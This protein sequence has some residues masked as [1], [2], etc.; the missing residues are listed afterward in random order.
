MATV[1]DEAGQVSTAVRAE[2]MGQVHQVRK[3]EF[4]YLR[5]VIQ[6]D[7][8]AASGRTLA[9]VPVRASTAGKV[10]GDTLKKIDEIEAQLDMLW[11]ASRAKSNNAEFQRHN[12]AAGTSL[13]LETSTHFSSLEISRRVSTQSMHHAEMP[14]AVLLVSLADSLAGDS[15]APAAHTEA[16]PVS[17]PTSDHP[18][19]PSSDTALSTAST[20]FASADYDRAT[21]HLLRALRDKSKRAVQVQRLLA[22]LEIYRATGNQG[23]FDWSV[24][25]YFDYWDGC[26]PQW[27][28]SQGLR[29]RTDKVSADTPATNTQFALSG[30]ED[31]RVWRC[32]SVLSL[33]AV[34]KLRAHWLA[35]RHCGVDWTSLSTLDADASAALLA[36]LT[37]AQGAPVQLVFVDTPNLLYVLEQATPQGQPHVARS[38]WEL[39]F[40]LLELMQM[41]AAFDAAATDFCLTYLEPAP[42]WRGSPIHF[43]G[44]ARVPAPVSANDPVD[45]PWRLH[46]HIL[47]EKGLGLPA[48]PAH[49]ALKRVN[50]ACATLVR[51]DAGAIAQL[52]QWTRKAMAQKTE[53]HL[54]DVGVLVGAAWIA[55][56]IDAFAQ[57]HLRELA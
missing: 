24:L 7:G 8:D 20:L 3:Q 6:R 51:M 21:Q 31:A 30:L 18:A 36:C 42:V 27:T 50:I 33:G 49:P 1:N 25:E 16:R 15:L 19:Q 14:S 35:N 2:W 57:L 22:L 40:C 41:R 23:Q 45:T 9:G 5:S 29:T 55:A 56:G 39:R 11:M 12:H 52:L 26:T 13:L 4:A 46:G 28:T 37:Q 17:A 10:R 47:G 48:L 44:D 38:L 53:V 43:I 54:Q 32:P 34:R